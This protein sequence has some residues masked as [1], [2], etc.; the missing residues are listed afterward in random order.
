M[1]AGVAASTMVALL[2][3]NA[4]NTSEG[5]QGSFMII[6]GHLTGN[7]DTTGTFRTETFCA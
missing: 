7:G 2:L 5:C 6:N 1:L 3:A 4:T